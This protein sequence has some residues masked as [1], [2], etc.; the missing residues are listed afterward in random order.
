MPV[1][2]LLLA[3]G[4]AAVGLA[5]STAVKGHVVAADPSVMGCEA[6]C[7]VVAAG[8]PV[9]FIADGF[10]TS[11]RDRADLAGAL[12]GEDDWRGRALAASFAVWL[13]ASLCAV[14]ALRRAPA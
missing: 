8:W 1:R 13:V 9:P 6:G 4:V 5:A 14:W 7:A 12:F 10:A 2:S 3:V 11:P